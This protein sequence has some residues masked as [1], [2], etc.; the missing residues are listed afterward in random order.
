MTYVIQNAA[1]AGAQPIATADT[2]Q[3][4]TLGTVVSAVDPT[5]GSGEFIYLLGVASTAVGSWVT[6]YED[7]W[8]TA[9]LVA[10]AVGRTAV[11]MS[12]NVASSYGWYQIKGKAVGKALTGYLDNGDV[13]ATSTAGSVDD[14]VVVG[15]LVWG[16]RG[17]SA[18]ATGFADFEIDR[19]YTNNGEVFDSTSL[20]ATTAEI[21]TL[22]GVTAGT[23]AA[24]KAVV[25]D[26]NKDISAF[27]H[28][29]LN[30]TRTATN[31]GAAATGSTA[32]ETGDAYNHTTIL[33]VSTTLPAIAGGANLAVGKLLYTFPAG[34]IIVESA[35]M[36]LAIT[37]SQ[38]NIN[39]DTPDGG[40]G[41]VIGSG[42][43]ATLDGTATFEDIITG[44][45]F[46][47]CTGTAEVKTAIPT[48][49]V[50]L[51]IATAAAHTVHFNVADGWAASGDAAAALAG[52][53]VLNW[54]FMG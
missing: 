53:V 22:A 31:V 47:N 44:Q 33:T 16:A 9:L 40:L 27:R 17:A 36:S 3:R 45:T 49:A 14:A 18:V 10:D 50:P 13:Y 34:E 51:V 54:R 52:T 7:D 39:A 19:P 43:V 26:A 12:A 46:N 35:Y 2:T 48:A 1:L 6:Y 32:V 37:Q 15:D 20:T 30:T 28:V 29:T 23:V 42:V 38:G 25:V 11:A 24:S 4:H 8:S 21:N 41:T 5:Y